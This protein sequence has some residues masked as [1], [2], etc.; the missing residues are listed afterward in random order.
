MTGDDLE[1]YLRDRGYTVERITGNDDAQYTI[2]RGV[3]ITAGGLKG[4]TC[5]VA[6]LYVTSTPYLPPAAIHTHPALL[7]M[8][9]GEPYGT[10]VSPVG[11]GWQYWSR[12]Y[13]RL[14][15]PEGLWTHVLTILNDD[16]WPVP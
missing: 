4:S 13:D 9:G 11:P 2:V 16:R 10:S 5:D 8:Q 14:P 12:R 7:P 3:T 1:R 15:T 6:V